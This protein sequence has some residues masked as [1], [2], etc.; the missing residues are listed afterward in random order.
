MLSPVQI[1][2]EIAKI[3]SALSVDDFERWFRRASRNFHA[4]SDERHVSAIFEVESVLSLYR[5]G[6]IDEKLVAAELADAIRPF[7][8]KRPLP[9]LVVVFHNAS[10]EPTNFS[11]A[12]GNSFSFR[13]RLSGAFQ[14]VDMGA[15]K[16]A[17]IHA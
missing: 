10:Y 11:F 1:S 13:P 14:A 4:Y 7:E 9:D 16:A 6:E 15:M 5:L 2:K 12:S 17:E 3:G 8:E